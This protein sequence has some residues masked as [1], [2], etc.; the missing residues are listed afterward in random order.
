MTTTS[1]SRVA[2]GDRGATA[3]RA[4]RGYFDERAKGPLRNAV[5]RTVL[6]WPGVERAVTFGCPSYRVGGELF[7]FVSNQ[8]VVLTRLSAAEREHLRV[9]QPV[10]PFEANGRPVDGWA[11][12]PVGAEDAY[13]LRP[14]LRMSYE[15]V[16]PS[17]TTAS[18]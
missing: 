15:A 14:Y 13:A 10:A 3:R 16:A 6:P 5:E 1:G 17:L 4:A 18:P 9:R 8:G 7:A 11:A 2:P 12:V